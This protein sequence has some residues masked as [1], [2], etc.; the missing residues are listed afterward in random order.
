M[1]AHWTHGRSGYRCRHGRN[2]AHSLSRC[3]PR[4][5]YCREDQ[6]LELLQR[7]TTLYRAHPRLRHATAAGAAAGFR[8]LIRDRDT[9]FADSQ[10]ARR[11]RN[12]RTRILAIAR[13]RNRRHSER[14]GD[15]R[16]GAVLADI[17]LATH[18][19]ASVRVRGPT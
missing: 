18:R 1:D 10:E 12:Y 14:R 15:R 2:S 11:W 13:Y 8:F 19:W 17:D 16:A 7:D 4:L 9:R 3:Q 6:L 5:L